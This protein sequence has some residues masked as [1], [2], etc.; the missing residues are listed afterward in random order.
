MM[1]RE[2]PIQTRSAHWGWSDHRY[3]GFAVFGELMG[4]PLSG[5]VA[6]SVLG[7]RLPTEE[8][9]LLDEAAVALTLA[10]P[11]IWPLKMTRV[12]A[13]YGSA[14]PAAAAG[15]MVQENARVGAWTGRCAAELLVAFRDQVGDQVDDLELV[16]D[17]VR[18]H[19]AQH[20][21]VW[22]FGTPF[23]ERDERLV[24]LRASVER[25]GREGSLHWR[26]AR[27]VAQ[28]VG[29]IR[30]SEPNV[31]LGIAACFLDMGM[32]PH[33]VGVMAAALMQHMF[34]AHASE[35]AHQ[36]APSLQKLPEACVE[37]VGRPPRRSPRAEA[38]E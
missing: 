15:L 20:R 31:S 17:V 3:F 18:Q 35:A 32:R 16:G 4:E 22:G 26:L 27:N 8:L 13:S 19:L 10:D 9:A 14:L 2:K 21:F 28:L 34:L 6:L 38:E 30:N 11:R 36:R 7:R 24:A 33:E 12:L 37:F 23:R 29:S 5:M 1:E 25:H